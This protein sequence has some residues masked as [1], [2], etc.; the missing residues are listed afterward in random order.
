[1]MHEMMHEALEAYHRV[2][3]WD[4]KDAYFVVHPVFLQELL[5]AAPVGGEPDSLFGLP[6]YVDPSITPSRLTLRVE[7]ELDR[8]IRHQR[9]LG[10]TINIMPPMAVPELPLVIEPTLKSLMQAWSKKIRKAL[11]R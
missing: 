3:P 9:E 10:R 5:S 2:K 8:T 1:M 6:L 11:T 4:R 7:T